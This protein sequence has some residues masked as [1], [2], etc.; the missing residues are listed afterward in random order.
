MYGDIRDELSQRAGRVHLIIG[1]VMEEAPGIYKIETKKNISEMKRT[2][3]GSLIEQSK[4]SKISH[5]GTMTMAAYEL[6]RFQPL[7]EG[8]ESTGRMDSFDI[9]TT[10]EDLSTTVGKRVVR[11]YGCTLS[12]DIPMTTLDESSDDAA[13][14]EINFSYRSDRVLQDFN[15]PKGV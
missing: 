5:T 15:G 2:P 6:R 12:G 3:L 9:Q 7:I 1:G 4:P 11:Y 10:H 13:T 8:Y 14:V